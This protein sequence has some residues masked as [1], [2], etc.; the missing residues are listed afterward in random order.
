MFELLMILVIAGV[1]LARVLNGNPMRLETISHAVHVVESADEGNDAEAHTNSQFRIN[2]A[3]GLPMVPGANV[4]VEGNLYGCPALNPATGLPMLWGGST[5]L[6]VA[7]N[8][9][10]Y[11]QPATDMN[12]DFL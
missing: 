4:D 6:D 9:Y 7:G 11:S 12:K 10:G 5:G 3:T 2:P 1:L 8:L